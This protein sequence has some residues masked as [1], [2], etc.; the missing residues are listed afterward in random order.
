MPPYLS[1]LSWLQ[2]S[3]GVLNADNRLHI[4]SFETLNLKSSVS[5]SSSSKLAKSLNFIKELFRLF[6]FNLTAENC[7]CKCFDYESDFMTIVS[8]CKG[9]FKQSK[10]VDSSSSLDF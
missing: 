2:S 10:T 4:F 1:S 9:L 6:I 8:F 5:S 7:S 3:I